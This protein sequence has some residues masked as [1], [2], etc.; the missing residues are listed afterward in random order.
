M[1]NAARYLDELQF[2]AL[3]M[4]AVVRAGVIVHPGDAPAT[5]FSDLE[6]INELVECMTL[7][8]T[9]RKQRHVELGEHVDVDVYSKGAHVQ[10][11]LG[12][13]PPLRCG[14]AAGCAPG[15][16]ARAA[17]LRL[18]DLPRSGAA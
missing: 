11:A 4:Y 16:C 7:D 5:P 2:V 13:A 12:R 3:D 18:R 8:E 17:A 14:L 10:G 1:T 15:M 6:I 9:Q